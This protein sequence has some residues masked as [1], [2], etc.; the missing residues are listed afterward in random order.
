L[1]YELSLT[2]SNCFERATG[3]ARSNRSSESKDAHSN[4]SG[5]TRS[6]IF[7]APKVLAEV[8]LVPAGGGCERFDKGAS[9]L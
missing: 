7:E 3:E 1:K 4:S 8:S 5:K 6:K 2:F 9:K